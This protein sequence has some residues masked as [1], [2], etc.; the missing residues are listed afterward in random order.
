MSDMAEKINIEGFN[1]SDKVP[2]DERILIVVLHGVGGSP[3]NMRDVIQAVRE[4]Y[5][6]DSKELGVDFYVPLLPYS[7]SLSFTPATEIVSHLLAGMDRIC[8]NP[9]RYSRIVFIGHSLGAVFARRLFL[10]ATPVAVGDPDIP[11][12][13]TREWA[14]KVERIISLGGLN[15]GWM[16]SG[17]LGWIYSFFAN[18]MAMLGHLS[19]SRKPTLFEARRGAPFIVQTRLQWLELRQ[20]QDN[21]KPTP[22][23]IQLLGTQ[24]ELVAPDDA[25]DFAVDRSKDSPYFYI[26][27]PHTRHDNAIIFSPSLFD[28]TGALGKARKDIFKNTINASEKELADMQIPAEYLVDNLPPAPDTS[29]EHVVFIIHGIR[30]DGYW[31]RKV[32]QRIQQHAIN[33]PLRCITPSYGYFAIL[34]FLLPWVRRLK[35]EWL[36]DE[37]VGARARYPKAEFSYVGHSNGTYLV[38]RALQDYPSARFCNILFAGSVVIRRYDWQNL[39]NNKRVS[40]VLNMVATSDWVVALFPQGLEPLQKF[41]DLGGAGFGGFNQALKGTNINQVQYVIGGHSAALTESQWPRIAEFIV[42]GTIPT[43]PDPD[44]QGFQ[45]PFWK[46]AARL[47]TLIL[48]SII[49]ILIVVLVS[50]LSPIFVPGTTASMAAGRTLL[51][52]LYLMVLYFIVTRV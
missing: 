32:A 15:R 34:P 3:Q 19:G 49:T 52:V 41:F 43:P 9:E 26:E 44:Y 42:N 13:G 14:S 38:A 40:K 47:S 11:T 17:R 39:I 6:K 23:I 51:A 10:A 21:K 25:V 24:D 29:I 4:E 37:Y 46:I 8:E 28:R 2:V 27:L 50:I 16:A 20:D 5:S 45:S 22:K 12:A 1:P 7:K 36:M 35:V 33:K 48:V 30:D 31:T 18:S